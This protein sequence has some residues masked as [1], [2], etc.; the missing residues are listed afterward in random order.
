MAITNLKNKRYLIVIALVTSNLF[1]FQNC[2]N[3]SASLQSEDARKSTN[4]LQMIA[5]NS[6][7]LNDDLPNSSNDNVPIQLD[8]PVVPSQE[9]MRPG[10]H[11]NSMAN[12]MLDDSVNNIAEEPVKTVQSV[13]QDD[14]DHDNIANDDKDKNK[15]K[16]ADIETETETETEKV[17]DNKGRKNCEYH[18]RCKLLAEAGGALKGFNVIVLTA[19]HEGKAL[20]ASHGKTIYTYSG[21]TTLHL[22]SIKASG[23]T[24]ICGNISIKNLSS[25]GNCHLFY[26][27]VEQANING[28]ISTSILDD[29]GRE[30]EID[31]KSGRDVKNCRVNSDAFITSI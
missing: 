1:F 7:A 22:Q 12:P 21:N 14:E 16:E 11:V 17:C 27:Q 19:V 4:N 18:N 24:V 9:D 3:Y 31:S 28:N 10:D 5:D 30:K 26:T 15:D 23:N 2:A 8:S 13:Q 6:P 20:S 25:N 29:N